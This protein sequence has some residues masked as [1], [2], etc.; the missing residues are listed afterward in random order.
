MSAWKSCWIFGLGFCL[1]LLSA[2]SSSLPAQSAEPQQLF[3]QAT[4]QYLKGNF[5]QAARLYEEILQKGWESGEVYYNLGNSYYRQ[6]N[7]AA[8][9]LNYERARRFL[10]GDSDL[11]RNLELANLRVVDKIEPLPEFLP[12]RWGKNF[13]QWLP[14]RAW[15]WLG[16]F[17]YWGA[18]ALLAGWLLLRSTLVRRWL[19]RG[20]ISSSAV[21]L[22]SFL[23]FG[24]SYWLERSQVPAIIMASEAQ[25]RSA[26]GAG[27]NEVFRVHAGTRVRTGT[28]TSEWTE[29]I[30]AD[31]KVGWVPSGS[32]ELI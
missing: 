21:A 26:P 31:G 6:G 1:L 19:L 10:P 3:A 30:L 15:L 27:A 5:E 23:L 14:S 8:A 32:L 25:A 7:V 18:T 17:F 28:R 9:I 12:V 13:L 16:M 2:T 24:G 4:Q 29:I 11:L 20:V 22:L